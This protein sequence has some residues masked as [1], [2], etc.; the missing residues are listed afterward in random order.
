MRKRLSAAR[1]G[2][3]GV[4]VAVLTLAACSSSANSATSTGS[5]GSGG[6]SSTSA[7]VV[8]TASTSIGKVLTN[9]KGY[10][11]YWFSIDTP[12]ASK[13]TGS[14]TTFWPPVK[15]PVSA[16]SGVSLP[17][18]FGTIKRS[19]GT[20]QATY[21]GHPLYTYAGDKAPGQTKGNG[22]NLSGGLWTA[23]TP[24]GSKP[25]PSPSQSSSSGGYGGY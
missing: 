15:G 17:G 3:A 7:S 1:L 9:A 4:A 10:T 11:I 25:A 23:M 19:D 22:L 13:C 16:A 12:T 6:S 18:K 5:G 21:D 8:K 14:C 2:A 24:S 20:V